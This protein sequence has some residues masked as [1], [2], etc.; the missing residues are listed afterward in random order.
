[1][2][3]E[4]VLRSRGEAGKAEKRQAKRGRAGEGKKKQLEKRI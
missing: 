4:G 2:L 1:M 3:V